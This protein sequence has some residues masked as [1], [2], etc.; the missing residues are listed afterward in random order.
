MESVRS[1]IG[2]DELDSTIA[3]PR[4]MDGLPGFYLATEEGDAEYF[5]LRR[6]PGAIL[7]VEIDDE[8]V[9]SLIKG[10]AVMRPIPT[11]P[12][13]AT[14]AGDELYIPRECFPAFNEARDH[15]RIGMHVV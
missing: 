4:H 5:A 1:L 13:S 14:F 7:A 11:S 10:G 3:T 12:M 9:E 2:G 6:S 8:I 15:G